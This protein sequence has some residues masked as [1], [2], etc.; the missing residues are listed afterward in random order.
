M[1]TLNPLQNDFLLFYMYLELTTFYV[2]QK[3]VEQLLQ[4]PRPQR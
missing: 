1:R 2:I 3:V 4:G